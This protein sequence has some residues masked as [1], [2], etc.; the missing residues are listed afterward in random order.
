MA[1]TLEPEDT[2]PGESAPLAVIRVLTF[3]GE[4]VYHVL[5]ADGRVV[6]MKKEELAAKAPDVYLDYLGHNRPAT[7]I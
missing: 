3:R 6:P 1:D 7:P 4:V 5:L 2:P